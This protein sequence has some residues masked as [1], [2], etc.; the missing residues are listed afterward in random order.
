IRW[1]DKNGRFSQPRIL[2]AGDAAGADPLFGEGI[3]FALGYG[4]VAAQAVQH[5]FASGDFSMA[6]YRQRI[7]RDPLLR[8]LPIRVWLARL[9]YLMKYP[10]L[11]RWG[12]RMARRIVRWTP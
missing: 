6:D 2:L 1:F 4:L 11:V 9:A 12:W 8:S 10:W 7:I 5:A 3:S